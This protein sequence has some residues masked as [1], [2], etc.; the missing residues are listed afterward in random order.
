M[1]LVC[2]GAGGCAMGSL[3][4]P[5]SLRRG[6][7]PVEAALA[8]SNDRPWRDDLAVLSTAS[9]QRDQVTIR[10]IRNCSYV[11]EDDYEV[12]HY[13][14]S[15]QLA[16]L[17]GV[18]FIVVP[19]KEAPTLAHTMLS[20]DFGQSG[21]VVV[22]VEAR[23]EKGEA[24]SPLAGSARQYELMYVIGDERD[25][26]RL[27]T[28]VRDVDVFLYRTNA[29]PEQSREILVDILRRANQL[30][31]QPEFYDSLT[32]NCTSNIVMHV[33]RVRPNRVPLADL[34]L[35]LPGYADQ[36]AYDLG[37]LDTSRPFADL[38]REAQIN[39]LARTYVDDPEFSERIR[40]R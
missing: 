35:L 31:R 34:R 15:F 23:L 19:F 29:T 4:L 6:G 36:M 28:Q 37:L 10:N 38:R 14:K 7:G 12:D 32:N 11:T 25:L 16:E 40:R 21:H 13:D 27:R 5:E 18:D 20:F 30:A 33:N 39:Y 2:L 8:P 26:I 17:R 9:I 3:S 22:S 24:Y 1:A